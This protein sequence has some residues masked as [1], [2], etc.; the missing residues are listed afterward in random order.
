MPLRLLFVC[1]MNQ[2]RSPTAEAMYRND[3]RLEVRSA[4]VRSEAK[5][6]LTP[7]EVSWADAIFV[8]EH[9][10]K[11]W[12]QERFR[13]QE[14]PRII[15]LDIPDDFTYLDPELQRLLRLS[16]DPEL[17]SLLGS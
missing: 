4:G 13:E 1:A 7:A 15:V 2:W 17:K 11:A 14:L 16:I 10:H 6:R 3:A 8:M 5:R 12:I 9:K